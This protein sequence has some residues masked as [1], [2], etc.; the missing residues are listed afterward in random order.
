MAQSVDGYSVIFK[1][2]DQIA[3][4]FNSVNLIKVADSLEY[5][6]EML[7]AWT[8]PNGVLQVICKSVYHQGKTMKIGKI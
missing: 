4:G 7:D 8:L 6:G 5:G 2:K 1:L 3:K